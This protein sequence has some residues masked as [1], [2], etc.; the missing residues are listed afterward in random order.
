MNRPASLARR[1]R[2]RVAVLQAVVVA[3]A[4]AV[5]L[6]LAWGPLVE[7]DRDLGRLTE[8]VSESLVFDKDGVP[9]IVPSPHLQ[10]LG[11]G[12][13]TL[14]FAVFDATT[15]VA[16]EGSSPELIAALPSSARLKSLRYAEFEA[17]GPDGRMMPG[18]LTRMPTESGEYM[19]AAVGLQRGFVDAVRWIWA[20]LVTTLLPLL[21]ALAVG[22]LLLVPRTVA[23]ALK[24]LDRL[25]AQARA[26]VPGARTRLEESATPREITPLVSAV[27]T[28]LD[29]LD[30]AFEQQ[31]R[32]TAN[33]AHELR[34]PLAVLQARVDSLNEREIK[35]GFQRDVVRMTDLVDQLLTMARLQAGQIN[36]DGRVDL[37]E[38]ARTVLS[39]L[40]PLAIHDGREVALEEPSHAVWVPGDERMLQG[41]L[42]NLVLNALDHSPQGETVEVLVRDVPGKMIEVLDR[43]P[44]LPQGVGDEIYEPFWRTEIRR[45]GVGLGLAIVRDAM[46]LHGGSVAHAPRDGGG[47]VFRLEFAAGPEA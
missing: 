33:A 47:T 36:M 13:R 44:G 28:A 9:R 34:N 19:L 30:Q 26:I 2:V 35:A 31:R 37:R 29:R 27:N 38:V 24:P 16:V 41:A 15:G 4:V 5:H 23:R 20:E 6:A 12:A 43:G 25:S 10:Q 22:S 17:P 18:A 32:F 11:A 14:R 7:A 8:A 21:A 45:R 39:D 3:V 1:L 42:S 46:K 40:A